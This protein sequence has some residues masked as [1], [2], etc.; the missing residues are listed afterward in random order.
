MPK[1]KDNQMEMIEDALDFTELDK[2]LW[3]R[4]RKL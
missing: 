1:R 2:M 3:F 4:A